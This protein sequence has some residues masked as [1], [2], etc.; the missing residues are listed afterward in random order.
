[1]VWNVSDPVEIRANSGQGWSAGV[2]TSLSETRYCVTLNTPMTANDW[3][4]IT[5]KYAGTELVTVIDVLKHC[6]NIVPD[7]HIRTPGG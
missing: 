1:M 7:K 3:L 4:G 5:R 6:P 2:V